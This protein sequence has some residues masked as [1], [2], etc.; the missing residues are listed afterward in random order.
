MWA[1]QNRVL[2][3]WLKKRKSER[4]KV[5][6]GINS[7]KLNLWTFGEHVWKNVVTLKLASGWW[8]ARRWEPQAYRY[9]ELNFA[10]LNRFVQ[11]LPQSLQIIDKAGW[12]F[13]FWLW[14]LVPD[15]T[16]DQYNC[17]GING[18][19]FKLLNLL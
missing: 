8:W 7:P 18:C 3:V 12:H 5:W 16:S 11:I 6:E 1:L 14:D 2:S 10:N 19:C 17:D 9:R 15:W 4:F 13:D